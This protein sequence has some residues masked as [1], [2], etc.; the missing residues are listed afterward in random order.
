MGWFFDR[1]VAR[2]GPEIVARRAWRPRDSPGAAVRFVRSQR[3]VYPEIAG[4]AR[5]NEGR[6]LSRHVAQYRAGGGDKGRNR[7]GGGGRKLSRRRG[8]RE[9]LGGAFLS[10][11]VLRGMETGGGGRFKC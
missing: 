10:P 7:R 4:A 11:R 2:Q 1:D 3:V 8:M 9:G 5:K 6:N